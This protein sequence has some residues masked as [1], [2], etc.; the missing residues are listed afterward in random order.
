M[1]FKFL[2]ER[3]ICL[4]CSEFRL[5]YFRCITHWMKMKIR[6][7]MRL[8][9]CVRENARIHDHFLVQFLLCNKKNDLEI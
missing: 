1:S 9:P 5:Q 8:F 6:A 3:Y 7:S 2:L 4:K